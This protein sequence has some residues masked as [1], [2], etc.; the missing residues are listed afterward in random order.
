LRDNGV[1]VASAGLCAHHLHFDADASTALLSFI[2]AR[3]SSRHPTNSVKALNAKFKE[4]TDC[5]NVFSCAV[6]NFCPLCRRCYVNDEWDSQMMQCCT[7]HHWVHA[8]C[9]ELTGISLLSLLLYHYWIL[10][11]HEQS[12]MRTQASCLCTSHHIK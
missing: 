6:G 4:W 5:C 10:T 7:C 1:A 12:G 9:E 8:L 3:C 2:Q 11:C